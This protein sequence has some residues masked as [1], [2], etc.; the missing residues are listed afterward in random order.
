MAA[1]V[2]EGGIILGLDTG[3]GGAGLGSI[4][5][6]FWKTFLW[7]AVLCSQVSVGCVPSIN[8]II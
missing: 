4:P 8:D 1:G 5:K 7:S 6:S 3:G 2:E